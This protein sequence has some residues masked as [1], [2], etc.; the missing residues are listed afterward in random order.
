MTPV[1]A[2][3]A[4]QERSTEALTPQADCEPVYR[5]TKDSR[6]VRGCRS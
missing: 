5:W 2:P 3:S 6:I 1:I 4:P